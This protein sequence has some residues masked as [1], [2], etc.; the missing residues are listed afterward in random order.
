MTNCVH[1]IDDDLGMRR[2]LKELMESVGLNV[3]TYS[4]AEDFISTKNNTIIGCIISDVRMPKM[5]GVELQQKNIEMGVNFPIIFLTGFGDIKMA[6]TAMQKEA[7]DFIEKPFNNQYL[8]DRVQQAIAVSEKNYTE[9]VSKVKN[10]SKFECLTKREKEV[11]DLI[12]KG[13][14]N[15]SIAYKLDISIK[16]VEVHR[17]KIMKKYNASGLASLIGLNDSLNTP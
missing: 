17:S 16:T 4:S 8:I 2:L 10:L 14:T 13:E 6:V 11:F 9:E 12:V 15:K 1:I 7:F 5:S 3:K